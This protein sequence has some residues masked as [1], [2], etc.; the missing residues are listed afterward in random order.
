MAI[1]CGVTPE[2]TLTPALRAELSERKA[3]LIHFATG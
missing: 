2:G 1:A 3:E